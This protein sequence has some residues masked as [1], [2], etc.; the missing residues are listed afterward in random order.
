MLLW[1]SF[2]CNK[3]L[4]FKKKK[5]ERQI[6]CQHEQTMTKNKYNWSTEFVLNPFGKSC[7]DQPAGSF[8]KGVSLLLKKVDGAVLVLF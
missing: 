1:D 3:H 2:S 7:I 8:I 5:K 6:A 4:F